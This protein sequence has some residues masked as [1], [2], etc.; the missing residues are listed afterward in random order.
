MERRHRR[1]PWSAAFRARDVPLAQGLQG[2]VTTEKAGDAGNGQ[3][4]VGL[5]AEVMPCHGRRLSHL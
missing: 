3:G 4:G 5:G 2:H 1:A